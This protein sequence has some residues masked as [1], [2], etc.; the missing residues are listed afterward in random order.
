MCRNLARR[1]AF[2]PGESLDRIFL[3]FDP[4]P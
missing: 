3:D 1:V 4:E 2:R